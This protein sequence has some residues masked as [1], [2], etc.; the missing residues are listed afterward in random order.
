MPAHAHAPFPNFI[1][2]RN[3]SARRTAVWLFVLVVLL[4]G[5]WLGKCT[6]SGESSPSAPASRT[7]PREA[8]PLPIEDGSPVAVVEVKA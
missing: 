2:Q 1:D 3:C 5:V 4:S 8:Q 6:A 7:T